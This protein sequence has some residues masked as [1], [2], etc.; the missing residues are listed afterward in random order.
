MVL[1]AHDAT[2]LIIITGPPCTGKT[3]LG[4]WLANELGFPLFYKDQF[5]EILFDHL[6]SPNLETKRAF[7]RASFVC[8]QEIISVLLSSGIHHIIEANYTGPNACVYFTDL[9]TSSNVKLCE[10]HLHCD[11][12][13]L[14]ERF[15]ERSRSGEIHPGHQGDK[16]FKS[17]E[18]L[19]LHSEPEFL[20]PNSKKL[21][22]D[23]TNFESLSYTRILRE[24]KTWIEQ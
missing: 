1:K 16:Y 9:E 12:E 23:T 19:L 8:L 13:V 7:G 6:E 21:L 11:G 18:A 22:Y 14:I 2:N 15:L 17:L 20:A 10:I 4:R 3:T 5:K 24:I